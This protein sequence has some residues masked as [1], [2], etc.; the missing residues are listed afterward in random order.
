M[1]KKTMK[2]NQII[3]GA[4]TVLLG[5]AGYINFSGNKLDLAPGELEP[6]E[7]AFAEEQ[8]ETDA[9]PAE[10]VSGE[11]TAFIYPSARS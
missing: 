5:V 9:K 6:T 3:I 1:K 8:T 2:R 10:I 11:L 7:S 4:L